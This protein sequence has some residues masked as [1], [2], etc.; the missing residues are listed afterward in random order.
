[1]IPG[2][3][4]LPAR[5][6]PCRLLALAL[7]FVV[8]P[9]A[10]QP[11]TP[12]SPA[13]A[14]L[15]ALAADLTA[16]FAP[17]FIADRI[18]TL[19]AERGA[20]TFPYPKP[21][22]GAVMIHDVQASKTGPQEVQ[23]HARLLGWR[24]ADRT[25][26]VVGAGFSLDQYVKF[27]AELTLTGHINTL[28]DED[29]HV[30]TLELRPSR[31]VDASFTVA[32]DLHVRNEGLWAALVGGAASLV[33]QSPE[34]QARQVAREHTTRTMRE[35]LGQG[36]TVSVALCT[37]VRHVWFGEQS[38][39]DDSGRRSDRAG[40]RVLADQGVELHAGG[41]FIDGP[42]DARHPLYAR[43]ELEN[44]TDS[45]TA[46]WL[47]LPAARREVRDFVQGRTSGA[48]T[49]GPTHTIQKTDTLAFGGGDTGK[50]VLLLRTA[51]VSAPPLRFRYTVTSEGGGPQPVINC[52][53]GDH[54]SGAAAA[55]T[56]HRA[57]S[58]A[59]AERA[60]Q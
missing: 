47:P 32:N 16:G 52:P 29:R 21:A 43:I 26:E 9:A 3:P 22:L 4:S 6:R 56:A 15:D 10:A 58:H 2:S 18:L 37:G 12:D 8:S 20:T 27:S 24:W 50:A 60:A 54:G 17:R 36:V 59:S 34:K 35:R 14:T 25:T 41:L 7:A 51:G 19:S 23:L 38:L 44:P 57:S 11:S 53:T 13:T 55:A 30:L 42:F 28:Y 45:V 48:A 5:L 1:M 33:G 46:S 40:R 31:P 39:P 49:P